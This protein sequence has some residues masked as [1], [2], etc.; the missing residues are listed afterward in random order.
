[1]I[2]NLKKIIFL[3]LI[4][5]SQMYFCTQTENI[6]ESIPEISTPENT[7]KV[8]TKKS[9]SQFPMQ[10][11]T[12]LEDVGVK[13]EILNATYGVLDDK[14]RSGENV[15]LQNKRTKSFLEA[16]KSLWVHTKNKLENFNKQF[17][18]KIEK[19][20]GHHGEII[21]SG[22]T[23]TFQSLTPFAQEAAYYLGVNK[24]AG[25]AIAQGA[26]KYYFSYL[27]TKKTDPAAHWEIKG[28]VKETGI[29]T[30]KSLKSN[31]YLYDTKYPTQI[32]V[33][34]GSTKKAEDSEKF[35]I[36]KVVP[37]EK[38][39]I[40]PLL[41]VAFKTK[42]IKNTD[43][44]DYLNGLIKNPKNTIRTL[45][46]GITIENNF[47]E[48]FGNIGLTHPNSNIIKQLE[49]TYKFGPNTYQHTYLEGEKIQ[50]PT[51][52]ELLIGKK[53]VATEENIQQ[54]LNE[55]GFKK[56]PGDLTKIATNNGITLGINMLQNLFIWNEQANN[57]LPVVI[58]NI[59][60]K[61]VAIGS[62]GTIIIISNENKLYLLEIKQSIPFIYSGQITQLFNS[63]FLD[64]SIENK[65]RIWLID[66]NKNVF[67][68]N[69]E[70]KTL[71]PIGTQKFKQISAS[72][73]D[74][75]AISTE[76]QV[77]R[78]LAKANS[79][80]D[81]NWILIP[82]ISLKQIAVG[83]EIWG[84]GEFKVY[85]WKNNKFQEIGPARHINY[86]SISST[87]D[88]WAIVYNANKPNT[89]YKK[90][91]E[92]RTLNSP[93]ALES[94]FS[95]YLTVNP[96]N[97]VIAATTTW[98]E[99]FSFI[100]PKNPNSSAPLKFNQEIII[101]SILNEMYI[102]SKQ[103]DENK[104]FLTASVS[105]PQEATIFKVVNQL[106]K[107]DTSEI[108]KAF[109]NPI[110]LQTLEGLQL[111]AQKSDGSVYLDSNKG[112]LDKKWQLKDITSK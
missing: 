95:K 53:T 63:N 29:I 105:T 66:T 78:L 62:D 33:V 54:D 9:F 97:N 96:E 57:F 103:I 43:I 7:L 46:D 89:T 76:N 82:G 11:P 72:Q 25:W 51:K 108:E 38:G 14:I 93:I 49:I 112:S 79:K 90:T 23:V 17:I 98:P 106:N 71:Q 8:S 88:I 26:K 15:V 18:F 91:K 94:F 99:S 28:D 2:V 77:F 4:N 27:V 24:K 10:I 6:K 44:V 110:Y 34:E 104:S 87:G 59:E 74:V 102:T 47:N 21:K 42:K 56:V 65:N 5:I 19:L 69:L 41:T 75:W 80:N 83:K 40:N 70:T 84:I 61:D 85:K 81:I 111:G 50:I 92:V 58:K 35:Y 3:I 101:K 39:N 45:D 12:Q 32:G 86:V 109:T 100:D 1:M 107:Q 36:Y 64:V 68:T 60:L 37:P 30:L 55:I 16:D 52:K 13:L 22:D 31:K 20:N 48:V 67:Q 73:A